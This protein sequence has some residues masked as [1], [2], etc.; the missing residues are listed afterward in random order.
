MSAGFFFNICVRVLFDIVPFHV[1]QHHFV[2][3]FYVRQFFGFKVVTICALPD[4]V[5]CILSG[6]V[7]RWEYWFFLA[8][9]SVFVTGGLRIIWT[10]I[11]VP[12]GKDLLRLVPGHVL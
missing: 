11:E 9:A 12:L 3:A 1:G 7:G 4:P 2:S 10:W 6:F 5:W 8:P